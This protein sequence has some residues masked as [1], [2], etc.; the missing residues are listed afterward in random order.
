MK[1]ET[2]GIVTGGKLRLRDRQGF[3]T[4][5]T[6]WPDCDV[7][8]TFES[9]NVFRSA[10]QN[11]YYHGAVVHALARHCHVSPRQ[12]HEALKVRLLPEHVVIPRLDG[13]PLDTITIGGSTR[14]LTRREAANMIDRAVAIMLAI[15]LEL[16]DMP[17]V[18][19]YVPYDSPK[20]GRHQRAL[21]GTLARKS[22][23]DNEPTCADCR[24]RLAEDT[25]PA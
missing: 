10:Q 5:F 22:E 6:S 7:Y 21:C 9:A 8:A 23:H 13:S 18:S 12:M 3:E 25:G 16:T 2:G 17:A 15:G 1:Y 19:H 4:A 24:A 14:T 20:V 11:A